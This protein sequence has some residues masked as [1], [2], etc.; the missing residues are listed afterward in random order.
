MQYCHAAL[1]AGL[2]VTKNKQKNHT[3][4]STS[5]ARCKIPTIL[6]LVTEEVGATFAP[7][8]FWDRSSSFAIGNLCKN[9]PIEEKCLQLACL[10]PESDQIKKLK[11]THLRV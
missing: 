6:G 11:A 8:A 4:L 1:H 5:S 9:A 10:S 7:P 2:P 3:Y